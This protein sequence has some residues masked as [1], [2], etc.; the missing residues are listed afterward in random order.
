MKKNIFFRALFITA[1]FVVTDIMA[2]QHFQTMPV[3]SG[4]T[5]DVIANGTGPSINSTTD[6]F[7]GTYYNLVAKDF[8]LTSTSTALTY[9]LPING[10]IYPGQFSTQGLSFQLGDLSGNNSLRLHSN[11]PGTIGNSGT[12]VFTN[13]VAAVKLYMLASS[14]Q[15][16]SHVTITVNFTD[17]TTQSFTQQQIPS[18]NSLNTNYAI[19]GMGRINRDTDELQYF[20]E[21]PKLYYTIHNIDAAN[22]TKPIQSIT[23]KKTSY[24]GVSNIFAFSVDAY[25]DCVEPA[26]HPAGMVTSNSAQIS[27]T[28]P[29]G[30][31][32]VSHDI[33]YSTSPTEPTSSTI[34]NYSGIIGTSYTLENLSA[35]TKYYY[36][37]R[38]NC[39]GMMNQS[40]W[41]LQKNFTTLCGVTVP[42]YTND[43]NDHGNLVFPGKCW[44]RALSGGTP[45]TGPTG[46]DERWTQNRFLNVFPH[47]YA[48]QILFFR[49]NK[50][51][52]LTTPLFDLSTGGYKVKFNYAGS[53]NT[54]ISPS[55]MGADDVV[56]FMV[57]NDGGSTWIILK[58]WDAN[59]NPLNP[60]N[61]YAQYTYNLAAYTSTT[62]RFAFYASSG[63]LQNTVDYKFFVDDFVIESNAQLSNSEVSTQSK[64]ITVHPNPFKDILYLSDIN[65][66][67]LKKITIGDVSGRIVK[68]T[69]GP[70]KELDL[71]TVNAGLYII[72]ITLK[73]GSKSIMKIIKQ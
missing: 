65:I 11:V 72:T 25:T 59:N 57:S 37:V 55:Q 73:D 62:T 7:D 38:T 56:H 48:A 36:W 23:V 9:G 67:E 33:Y 14:G 10:I 61:A 43:F 5:A 16:T 1:L 39:N 29:S 20:P 13:P 30:T 50:I 18:W 64:G 19:R 68:T 15:A 24:D 69:E 52:W 54:T 45:A 53:N 49:G 28:V 26:L 71:S 70:I 46:T 31:Q 51:S 6:N 4:Y 60:V 47:N 22:Y 17:N 58:T 40:Q 12:L 66:K 3:Q 44:N 27:W 63:I 35:I 8:K 32:A 42:P 41:S 34:P 21:D 2:Q